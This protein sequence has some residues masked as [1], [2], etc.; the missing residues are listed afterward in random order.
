M[1]YGRSMVENPMQGKKIKLDTHLE[2]IRCG[3]QTALHPVLESVFDALN[4]AGVN[5][6]LTRLPSSLSAPTGDIDLLVDRADNARTGRILRTLGFGTL[7]LWGRP[8]PE[9]FYLLYH[10]PTGRNLCLHVVTQLSFGTGH[11]IRT[12]TAAGCLHRR[13][14]RDAFF[15]P[16]PNDAFW[17]LFLHCL[18]DKGNVASRYQASLQR[19]A[20]RVQT[21]GELARVAEALCPAGW[22]ASRMID[23]VRR[24]DWTL[25]NGLAQHLRESEVREQPIDR[26][27]QS[28]AAA[29]AV[30]TSLSVGRYAW[31][32]GRSLIMHAIKQPSGPSAGVSD[33]NKDH[34]RTSHALESRRILWSTPGSLRKIG[35]HL[36]STG[37]GLSVALLGPDGVGKST[38]AANLAGSLPDF[39]GVRMLYMG[40]GYGGLPRLARLPIPGSLAAV[41]LLTLW[42]R[43]L[44]ARYH[45]KRGRLVVFDRYTYDAWLPPGRRLS[46]PQR[47]ARWVWAHACPAPDLVLLLDAPGQA[48]YERRGESEPAL[49]EAARQDFLSLQGRIAQLQVVDASRPE[50]VVRDDVVARIRRCAQKEITH[51][52]V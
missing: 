33:L 29:F 11:S 34:Q 9:T 28:V 17:T 31:E 2:R 48:V 27:L 42:W 38:L 40:L 1:R 49:L 30:L 15:E 45:R 8:D 10:P 22:N 37:H 46:G 47:L 19:L 32:K 24:G 13:R 20:E 35:S 52:S 23:R 44:E 51:E 4:L 16:D 36:T 18:L 41:G 12:G 50:A 25:L 5:W 14:K 6:C 43:Y 3:E 26:I 21:D 7:R 39:A